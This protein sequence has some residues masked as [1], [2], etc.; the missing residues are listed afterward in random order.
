MLQ[1]AVRDRLAKKLT[2]K[3]AVVSPKERITAAFEAGSATATLDLFGC[4]AESWDSEQL[5]VGHS[6]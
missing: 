1:G 4:S 2:P 6:P 3:K 5:L